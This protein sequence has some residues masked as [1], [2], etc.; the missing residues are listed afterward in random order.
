MRTL[1][2]AS[3]KG[4]KQSAREKICRAACV[5][6]IVKRSVRTRGMFEIISQEKSRSLRVPIVR[7]AHPRQMPPF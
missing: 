6:R 3:G 2:A 7:I 1:A 4:S 5:T